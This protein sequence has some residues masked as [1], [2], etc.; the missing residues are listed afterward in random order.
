MKSM[1]MSRQSVYLLVITISLLIFVFLFAFFVL[2]PSGQEY[3]LQRSVTTKHEAE[4]SQYQQLN[5][6]TSKQLKALQAKH[7]NVIAAFDNHFDQ[8]RFTADNRKYFQNLTLSKV[9]KVDRQT[10]FDLYEVNATSKINSPEVF[11]NFLDS[12][13]KGNW[14]IGVNFPIHFQK[15]G[16]FIIASFR[17]RVYNINEDVNETKMVNKEEPKENNLTLPAPLRVEVNTTKN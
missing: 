3:R 16:E 5:D 8:A 12:L 10:P 4:L 14:I 17:M 15:E 2:I 11:Y 1:K 6:D 7:Q 9:A 13:N